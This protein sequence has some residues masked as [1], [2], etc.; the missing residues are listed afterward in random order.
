ME[1]LQEVEEYNRRRTKL[2]FAMV[3]APTDPDREDISVR[4]AAR[5]FTEVPM[6]LVARVIG[7]E[8]MTLAEWESTGR[9]GDK[10]NER[11][12]LS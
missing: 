7:R 10:L 8:T 5:L 1:L 11:K 9:S 12:Q 4:K 6:Y 2:R 3:R